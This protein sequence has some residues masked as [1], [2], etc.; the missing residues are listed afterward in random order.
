MVVGNPLMHA[1]VLPEKRCE[2]AVAGKLRKH[3]REILSILREQ[4]FRAAKRETGKFCQHYETPLPT[5]GKERDRE[6]DRNILENACSEQGARMSAMD[7][8]SRNAGDM[9]DR[10]TLTYNRTRQASITTELIEIISGASA[11]EG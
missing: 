4:Q 8:S 2:F 5:G 10:L 11:L 1:E 7:S 6:M 9:L 3:R